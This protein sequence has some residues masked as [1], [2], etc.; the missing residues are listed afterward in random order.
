MWQDFVEL[1]M[2]DFSLFTVEHPD[3]WTSECLDMCS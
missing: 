1:T 3:V 2:P